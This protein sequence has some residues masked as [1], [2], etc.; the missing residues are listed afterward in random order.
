MFRIFIIFI[1]KSKCNKVYPMLAMFYQ[2]QKAPGTPPRLFD[3]LNYESKS[4]NN[5]RR[6]SWGALLGSYHFGGRGAC[7]SSGMGTRKSDKQVNY[8]H[9]FAQTQQVG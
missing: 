7:W 9:R 3:G 4:E 8:S 6:K 2:W 5:G 1:Y